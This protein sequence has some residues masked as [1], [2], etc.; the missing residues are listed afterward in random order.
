LIEYFGPILIPY[1]DNKKKL[2]QSFG[3]FL[4][5]FIQGSR[6][7]PGNDGSDQKKKTK[8]IKQAQNSSPARSTDKLHEQRVISRIDV[9]KGREKGIVSSII[10]HHHHHHHHHIPRHKGEKESS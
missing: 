8:E 3:F 4:F 7:A 9:V 1:L 6:G 10:I 5:I 2:S